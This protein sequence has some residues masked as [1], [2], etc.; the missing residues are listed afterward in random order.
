R[1]DRQL[2]PRRQPLRGQGPCHEGKAL[3]WRATV[4]LLPREPP[5]PGASVQLLPGRRAPGRLARRP[6]PGREVAWAWHDAGEPMH[7]WVRACPRE[8]RIASPVCPTCGNVAAPDDRF[9]GRC[10]TA[11][12]P[13]CPRCGRLLA[14]DVA[15]CTGCGQ[16]LAGAGSDGVGRTERRRVSVLFIDAVGSTPY[17]ER[18][19]PERVR[20]QQ[21]EFYAA[22]RRIVRRDGGVVE[23]YIGDA[24]MVLFGAPVTTEDDAIR[25][26]RA[27]LDLQRALDRRGGDSSGEPSGGGSPSAGGSG[28]GSSSGGSSSGEG[29][30]GSD[31][32]RYRVGIATGEALVD[33]AAAHDGGQAIV[34]GDVVNTA[35]RLQTEAPPGG[36]LVCANTRAAT[37]SAIRYT[38]RP[39]LLLR[40]RSAPTEVWLA[41]APGTG[42]PDDDSDA[43]PLV[44]REHELALLTGALRHVIEER[45]PRLVTV[46]GPAGIGKSRLVRELYRHATSLTDVRVQWRS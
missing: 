23:K 10:G 31:G 27:A 1:H 33:V 45:S 36:V 44:G 3:P 9:C 14:A 32:W 34:A 39:P 30:D 38:A 2:P 11:L 35:A 17:A 15:F 4:Q 46:L 12:T 21:S 16:P 5:H 8:V 42:G 6:G 24:A 7:A 41:E 20:S 29:S 22:V 13:A 25:C 18:A 43:T 37:G 19:D 26:V 28:G 40:G